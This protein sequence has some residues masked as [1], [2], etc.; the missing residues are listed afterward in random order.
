[1]ASV[2]M[3]SAASREREVAILAVRKQHNTRIQLQ[4]KFQRSLR[5]C[6]LSIICYQLV[7]SRMH[8]HAKETKLFDAACR[9]NIF[10]K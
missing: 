1:M 8:Q 5:N 7:A 2:A 4:G 6:P 3:I 9:Y 10:S